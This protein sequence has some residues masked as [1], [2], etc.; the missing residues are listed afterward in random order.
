[1]R[2]VRSVTAIICLTLAGCDGD[3]PSR[4][5]GWIDTGRLRIGNITG[6]FGIAVWSATQ[7]GSRAVLSA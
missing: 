6:M 1:M 5:A 4:G 3:E 2:F 7:W